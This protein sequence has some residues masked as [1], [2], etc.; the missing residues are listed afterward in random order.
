MERYWID[1]VPLIVDGDNRLKLLSSIALAINAIQA[2]TKPASAELYLTRT[3]WKQDEEIKTL[4]LRHL[5]VCGV[6]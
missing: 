3:K 4:P 2:D 1:V 6:F 5:M